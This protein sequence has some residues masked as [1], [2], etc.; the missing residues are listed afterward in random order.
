MQVIARS[1]YLVRQQYAH[2]AAAY[3]MEADAVAL[4]PKH[5][6]LRAFLAVLGFR[7]RAEQVTQQMRRALRREAA[8]H[9]QEAHYYAKGRLG[10]DTLTSFLATCLDNRFV[11]LRNYTPP[12]PFARGGDI[13]ALLVGPHGV[14]VF[15]V[16]TWSGRFAVEQGRWLCW[17]GRGKGWAP[18]YE[19]PTEQ[20]HANMGRIRDFLSSKG[21]GG[22]PV[23]PVI[24]AGWGMQISRMRAPGAYILRLG[25]SMRS[26]DPFLGQWQRRPDLPWAT[27]LR[28]YQALLGIPAV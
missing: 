7:G 12:A 28:V 5:G 8:L 27:C 3:R 13:D 6:L 2:L 16:K 20:V 21:L 23:V 10:E 25:R 4:Q 22:I 1:D 11:L 18:A 24:A 26:P 14:T 15:E 19:N 17:Q 9:G